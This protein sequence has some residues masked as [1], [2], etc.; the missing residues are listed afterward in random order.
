MCP[1]VCLCV[2]R[3]DR[4]VDAFDHASTV[5]DDIYKKLSNNPSA[6]AFLGND[7][8][9]VHMFTHTHIH[10]HTH[11]HTINTSH[12]Q[13]PYLDGISFNCIAPG[14]RYVPTLGNI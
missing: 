5:I 3:Y 12:S 2:C 13:E 8:A 6:Q 1:F 4:F 9:E 7:N 10:T 11:T 14:K